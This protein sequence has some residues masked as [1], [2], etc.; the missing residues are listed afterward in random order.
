MKSNQ[1]ERQLNLLVQIISTTQ[2]PAQLT[3]KESNTLL[4]NKN[5]YCRA[6]C[7]QTTGERLASVNLDL[8]QLKWREVSA[9]GWVTPHRGSNSGRWGNGVRGICNF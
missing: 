1:N 3:I 9:A 2:Y 8:A 5:D 7:S 6:H 4:I